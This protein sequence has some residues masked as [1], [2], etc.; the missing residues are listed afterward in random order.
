MHLPIFDKINNV[1]TF[2]KIRYFKYTVQNSL[3]IMATN[4]FDKNIDYLADLY[5]KRW[6]VELSFKRLKSQLSIEKIFSLSE[7]CFLQ[8]L[9]LII[10]KTQKREF[11][12]EMNKKTETNLFC[13]EISHDRDYLS[14]V[15]ILQKSILNLMSKL[16]ISSKF[17][18]K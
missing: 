14:S 4:I 3:F 10:L 16:E 15:N 9:Q 17:K 18:I 12:S 5:K 13:K 6:R 8:D 7:K 1:T 11:V 2:L